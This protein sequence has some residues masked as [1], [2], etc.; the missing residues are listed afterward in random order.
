MQQAIVKYVEDVCLKTAN[1]REGEFS[2]GRD[3]YV[4]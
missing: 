1:N 3:L 2:Q 4:L